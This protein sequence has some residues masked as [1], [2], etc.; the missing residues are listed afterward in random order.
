MRI[1]V[2]SAEGSA[3]ASERWLASLSVGPLDSASAAPSARRMGWTWALTM[4][5]TKVRPLE[6]M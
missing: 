2:N 3:H 4:A 1:P 6:L 5:A